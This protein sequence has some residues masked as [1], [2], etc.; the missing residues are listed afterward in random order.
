[1]KKIFGCLSLGLSLAAVIGSFATN[2][3]AQI[4]AQDD[5]SSYSN[6]P[7]NAAWLSGPNTNGGFGFTPWVFQHAGTGF[8]GFFIG[9]AGTIG[10]TNGNAWGQ[11]A[12]EGGNQTL[13]PNASVAF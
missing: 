4:I 7:A 8:Q 10:S 3:P 1:M 12:N 2:S 9:D 6:A 11:Y 5:A 13:F